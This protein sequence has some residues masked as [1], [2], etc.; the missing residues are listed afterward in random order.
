MLPSAEHFLAIA[1]IRLAW[2][3]CSSDPRS[4]SLMFYHRPFVG[5]RL[6]TAQLRDPHRVLANE[7]NGHLLRFRILSAV[8]WLDRQPP[9]YEYAVCSRNQSRHACSSGADRG[10]VKQ[11]R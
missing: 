10:V 4:M 11:H 6:E 1:R 9:E 7:V 2:G 3:P 8:L 5:S